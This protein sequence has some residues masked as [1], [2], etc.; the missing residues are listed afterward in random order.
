MAMRV[1]RRRNSPTPVVS[2]LLCLV[3]A[4]SLSACAP[5][6]VVATPTHSHIETTPSATP[7]AEARPSTLDVYYN[8][9]VAAFNARPIKE[10]QDTLCA[11][12]EKQLTKVGNEFF[13]NSKNEIDKMPVVSKTNTPQQIVSANNEIFVLAAS[14]LDESLSLKIAGCA[15]ED[16]LHSPDYAT[17]AKTLSDFNNR[18]TP[19]QA[20]AHFNVDNAPIVTSFEP[21]VEVSDGNGGMTVSQL[22]ESEVNNAG[23]NGKGSITANYLFVDG[24][25]PAW[26]GR[27]S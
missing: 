1:P 27:N 25:N 16:P 22:I 7:T 15:Y 14:T 2:G 21:P 13:Q 10:R 20:Q 23:A 8:E 18:G 6:T 24:D 5:S 11:W 19:P 26:V 9:P 3:L 4:G 17:V 12:E